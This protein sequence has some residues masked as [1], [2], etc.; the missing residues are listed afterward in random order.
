MLCF[1]Y[2]TSFFFVVGGG[3]VEEYCAPIFAWFLLCFF[4][5][6]FDKKDFPYFRTFMMGILLGV[7]FMVK[8]TLILFP[9]I[10]LVIWF[11][12]KLKQKDYKKTFISILI[13]FLAFLLIFI[14]SLI[15]FIVKDAVSDLFLVYFYDNLFLYKTELSILLNFKT[16]LF[17]GFVGISFVILG[18][19]VYIHKFD[20]KA[21][22][23]T[24]LVLSYLLLIIVS[25][26][27]SYYYQPLLVFAS[28]G[29]AFTV[30][31]LA[32]LKFKKVFRKLSIILTIVLCFGLCFP[33]GNATNDS[34]QEI[35]NQN[36]TI[37]SL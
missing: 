24:I 2:T 29:L 22:T 13:M 34:G 3:A 37:D 33:F 11:V 15:C 30:E 20:K 21:I 1:I 28:V 36:P 17:N 26:N 6:T 4:D 25:G 16:V 19:I 8:F 10:I 18:L 32:R 7:L 35:E 27:F 12:L 9:A 5:F 14:L 23:Y 31:Y